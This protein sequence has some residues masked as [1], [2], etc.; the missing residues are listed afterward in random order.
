MTLVN[1]NGSLDNCLSLNYQP[2]HGVPGFEVE[3]ADDTLGTDCS[4]DLSSCAVEVYKHALSVDHQCVI[5]VCCSIC[6]L[7]T[8]L[9][10][11]VCLKN[12][13]SPPPTRNLLP[14]PMNCYR[15]FKGGQ[16][17]NVLAAPP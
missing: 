8:P 9:P 15:N 1:D 5:I 10:T 3:T 13:N 6:C 2:V 4:L 11:V 7:F 12:N 17:W 16:I 14:P